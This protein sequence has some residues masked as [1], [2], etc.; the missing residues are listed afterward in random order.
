[1]HVLMQ[2]YNKQAV[3]HCW[4][5]SVVSDRLKPA[6]LTKSPLQGLSKLSRAASGVHKGRPPSQNSEAS[7]TSCA[8]SQWSRCPQG[9]RVGH[10]FMRRAVQKLSAKGSQNRHLHCN[11]K[12]PPIVWR[13]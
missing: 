1:M 3:Q 2:L 12:V 5:P 4:L 10:M 13:G 7:R 9:G 6:Y 8:I 11:M